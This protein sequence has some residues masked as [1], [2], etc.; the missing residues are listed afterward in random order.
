MFSFTE[1]EYETKKKSPERLPINGTE[2][3]A[4]SRGQASVVSK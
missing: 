2:I 4:T 1:P 3:K